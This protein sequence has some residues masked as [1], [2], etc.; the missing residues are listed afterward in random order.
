MNELEIEFI[1]SLKALMIRYGIILT[2]TEDACILNN[3]D[4]SIFL[5]LDYVLEKTLGEEV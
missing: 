1:A 4:G 3:Q 2:T 5:P